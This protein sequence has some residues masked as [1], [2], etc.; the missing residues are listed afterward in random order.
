M[1]TEQIAEFEHL[2]DVL[3]LL[4]TQRDEYE[5]RYIAARQKLWAELGQLRM[6]CDHAMPDGK[7]AG[8]GGMFCTTCKIC[9]MC[10]M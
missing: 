10:D 3:K 6:T 9:G 1:T 8:D 5:Q 2:D 4:A 7:S